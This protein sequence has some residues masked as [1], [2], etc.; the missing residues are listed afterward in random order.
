M[1]AQRERELYSPALAYVSGR[2]WADNSAVVAEEVPLSGRRVDCGVVTKS[3]R[4]LAF[5]FKLNN[6][7][8]ALWQASLNSLFFDRSFIV[9]NTRVIRETAEKAAALG[10]EILSIG[11]GTCVHLGRAS[12]ERPQR[13]VR[14]RVRESVIERG[15]EWD[16]YVRAL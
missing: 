13:V 12:N 15:C 6:T 11:H 3:G 9:V 2:R 5:E 7:S 10:V 8:K 14:K 16:E 1:R 4:L